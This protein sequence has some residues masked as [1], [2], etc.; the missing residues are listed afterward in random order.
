[1]NY[2]ELEPQWICVHQ[3][4]S[5]TILE[6]HQ[7]QWVYVPKDIDENKG[8]YGSAKKEKLNTFQRNLF[9][10]YCTNFVLKGNWT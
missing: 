1:M 5:L 4:V 6:L 8:D 7:L 3:C 10:I 2:L 9:C